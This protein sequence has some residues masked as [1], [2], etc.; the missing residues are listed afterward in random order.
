MPSYLA[1]HRDTGSAS[2]DTDDGTGATEASDEQS[3]N[4]FFTHWRPVPAPAPRTPRDERC[5]DEDP[6]LALTSQ[7]D[8][9][10]TGMGGCVFNIGS[11]SSAHVK[12]TMLMAITRSMEQDVEAGA[13]APLADAADVNQPSNDPPQDLIPGPPAQQ[14]V[15]RAYR[16]NAVALGQAAVDASDADRLQHTLSASQQDRLIDRIAGSP[17]PSVPPGGRCDQCGKSTRLHALSRG[18]I[19]HGAGGSPYT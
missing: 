9:L 14:R 19:A 1:L 16:L 11:Q 7:V 2:E 8:S 4:N 13:A 15:T 12:Q 3:A 6:Y 5:N 10:V 18:D 17:A